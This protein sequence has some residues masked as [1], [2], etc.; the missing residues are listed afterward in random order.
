MGAQRKYK[1]EN[2]GHQEHDRYFHAQRL[3][4]RFRI[5]QLRQAVEQSRNNKGDCAKRQKRGRQR[6]CRA[7][8]LKLG[9]LDSTG[10]DSNAKDE[11]NISNNGPG[12]RRLYYVMQSCP[13]CD[14]R[15]DQFC[16]VAEG[17]I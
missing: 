8:E 17:G 12:D 15:D 13:Q 6:R 9:K 3:L 1:T 4:Q 7:V 2:V 10:D 5:R 11:E 14:K 16:R